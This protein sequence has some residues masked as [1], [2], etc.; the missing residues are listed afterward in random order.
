MSLDKYQNLNIMFSF[1]WMSREYE[2]DLL[3]HNEPY[4]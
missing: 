1:I 2:K 3:L 4:K